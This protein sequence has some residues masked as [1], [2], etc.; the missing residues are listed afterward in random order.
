MSGQAGAGVVVQTP[1][2]R[3]RGLREGAALEVFRGIPYARPPV[4][5]LRLLA[6][7]PVEPWTG[8]L[9]ATGF[10]H[11]S[12][13]SLLAGP[14]RTG[15]PGRDPD[16]WLSLNLWSP[17][18]GGALPV[19][20]WLYGGGYLSGA[21]SNPA[22]DGSRIA[23]EGDVVV[24]T[25]DYR[26]GAEGFLHVDGAPANRGL[27]DQVA[28]LRW[29]R[30][31][32]ASFGGDPGRVTVFGQSAGAGSIAALLAVP[33]T[34]DLLGRAVLQSVPRTFLDPDLARQVGVEVAAAAGA[35]PTRAALAAVPPG[36][37]RDASDAVARRV[38]QQ[39]GRWGTLALVPSPYSPVV[40]GEVLPE[41]PWSALRR[42]ARRATPL[43]VG[44]TRDEYRLFTALDPS[45]AEVTDERLADVVGRVAGPGVA[46]AYRS[47]FPGA[48]GADLH[49]VFFSD[50]LFRM[51]AVDLASAHH[52]AGGSVHLYELAG[53]VSSVPG[54][55]GAPHGADVPL[56]FGTVPPSAPVAS[57]EL[58]ATVGDRMRRAWTRFAHGQDPGWAPWSEEET[59]TRL[60]D[61]RGGTVT[62]PE[63]VSRALGGP[64]EPAV[65]TLPGPRRP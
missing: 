23:V 19:M 43:L 41:T 1:S 25:L 40:D 52:A 48:S 8:E 30:E 57:R 46:D 4:G 62:Y 49:E 17:R 13:Q 51:P 42:G 15:A 44:H 20:V 34:E 36:D 16:A 28:A 50:W 6:P 22:Y 47:A 31:H 11:P 7:Q 45:L 18:R 5:A 53:D 14:A 27:L 55:R 60:F 58:V 26:V 56:V 32:V 39:V 63:Q 9:D 12:P 65:L 61:G 21:A 35:E 3:V 64:A 10:G 33:A 38:R 37:L 24:V 59:S 54:L 29:V 2:G